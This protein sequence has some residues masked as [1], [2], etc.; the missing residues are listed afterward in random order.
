MEQIRPGMRIQIPC[1]VK[2]GPFSGERLITFD[3]L[4]GPISGFV[5]E[6]AIKSTKSAWFIEGTVQS[7]EED[8]LVVKVK[9][10]FFTTNGIANVS[11]EMAMAA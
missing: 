6:D 1:E 5:K 2:P 10:S 11:K 9:G 8:H 7:V 3:T 4:D